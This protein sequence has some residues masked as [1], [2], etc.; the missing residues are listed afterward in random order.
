MLLQLL[1][2]FADMRQRRFAVE[3][4]HRKGRHEKDAALRHHVEQ[5]GLLVEVA[6]VLDRIDAGLDRD[7]QPAAAQRM[8]HDAAI[9]RMGFFG[10]RLH[11]VEVEGA[12]ARAVAR[13]RA[14][15]AGR[16]AFDDVGAGPD[17]RRTTGRTSARLLT[18]PSGSS[19]SLAHSTRNRTG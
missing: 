16:R 2:A 8:T 3:L 14:G 6:A 10:Q 5:F 18:T 1:G 9:E 17:D 7:A 13:A 19:G 11:L 4:V 15:A 12:V